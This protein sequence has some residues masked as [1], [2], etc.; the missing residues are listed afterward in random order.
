MIVLLFVSAYILAMLEEVTELRKSKPMVFAASL[1]WVIIAVVY[2]GGSMTEKAAMA[3]RTTLEAYAELFLFILVSMTYLNAM[4]DRGVFERLRVWLLNKNFNYRQ[5]FWITGFLAFGISSACNNLTTALLMGS[6]I[7]A[8]GKDNQRFIALSCV[9][10]VVAANAGGSFSPFGDITT[11]LVWQKGVVPFGDFFS[12]L[13]P[14][15]INFVVPA[16]IMYFW[17]PEACPVPIEESQPMKRGGIVIIFLFIL[18]I[19]TSAC[20]ENFLHLPPTA[21]MMLGLTYLK[22]FSYYLQKIPPKLIAAQDSAQYEAEKQIEKDL[23]V[24]NLTVVR[25]GYI[26]YFGP[27]K[28]MNRMEEWEHKKERHFDLP[29][30]VFSK[31]ANLEWDTLLFFYGVMLAVGGLSFVGYLELTSQHLYAGMNPTIANIL[32]GFASAF[33]DNGTIMLAVLTMAPDISQ[34]QWLLVTLTAGVGGSM[35]AVGSA[36]GVGLMGQTKGLYTFTSH[37]KCTPAIM[38]G[39]FAS[40]W[41][42]FL[43]NGRYFVE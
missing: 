3:F 8:M 39:F 10:V 4:E 34:G 29:F 42:H 25:E 38:L 2:A 22:F 1:I 15:M 35:L 14:A 32:V 11:L 37:L 5:L 21:G 31:V 17:I 9:N 23:A 41:V 30:D 33:V 40:I 27:M 36:A 7:L 43:I 19:I 18:T 26:D 12:L 13:I 16:A 28:I 20:F 24:K 6:V